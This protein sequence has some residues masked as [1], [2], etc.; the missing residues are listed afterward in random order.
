MKKII[1]NLKGEKAEVLS[2][3]IRESKIRFLDTQNEY[4]CRN[5]TIE[6][7][8]FY[9]TIKEEEEFIK[10]EWLQHCGDKVKIIKKKDSKYLI[11][12][13]NYPY[14]LLAAKTTIKAGQ[15]VNPQI[16]IEEFVK[17]EWKQNCGDSLKIIEKTNQK[18][19]NNK[20]YLW[21][22]S[23]I[24]YPYETLALKD[25]IIKGGVNNPLIEQNEFIGKEFL[26]HC[27][28]SLKVIRKSDYKK[29]GR[30]EIYYECEFQKYPCKVLKT[31]KEILERE[32]TNYNIPNKYGFIRGKEKSIK[33]IYSIWRALDRCYNP[34]AS[35][36]NFYKYVTVSDE[37]KRYDIFEKWYLE[38][39]KWNI[40][41]N[42][43][44]D[45]DI[46]YN[47]NHLENKVYSLKTCLL[48]P[49]EI[50]NFLFADN[51]NTGVN[52]TK[53]GQ[54]F[55]TQIF[56]NKEKIYLGTFNTF[57]EAKNKYAEEKYK[58]WVELLNQFE[59]PKELKEIL[60]QYDFS[61]YWKLEE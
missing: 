30:R 26:Q 46:L 32:C 54:K 23:F 40:K 12:F 27:G 41:Y 18:G 1:E 37:F 34:K 9:D 4:N 49:E 39:E 44:V 47:I 38:N 35:K 42:L 31:K 53:N 15:V 2:S 52:L 60:L 6:K 29:E 25:I 48:V 5:L 33:R 10:K 56:K 28:D 50:N 3:N 8:T 11:E 57:K 16:E 20:G 22:V 51:I 58:I 7:G 55:E 14:Q 24:N 21:K 19:N 17:K 36:Y 13:I 59:L 61:W 45:K 43:E